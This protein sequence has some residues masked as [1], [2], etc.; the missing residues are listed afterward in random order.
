MFSGLSK[1]AKSGLSI[2]RGRHEL[3]ERRVVSYI[4]EKWLGV[5][6]KVR[7][8]SKQGNGTAVASAKCKDDMMTLCVLAQ[9]I[10]EYVN[11]GEYTH[12]VHA[13]CT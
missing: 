13:S 11:T 3:R 8:G 4:R 6:K 5:R 2:M 9:V 1:D 12:T 10:G 7:N